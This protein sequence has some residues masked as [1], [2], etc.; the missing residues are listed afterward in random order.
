MNR[1][2]IVGEYRIPDPSPG[3]Y[4]DPSRLPAHLKRLPQSLQLRQ[5][6][7]LCPARYPLIPLP[8]REDGT[9]H[10]LKVVVQLL[11]PWVEDEDLEA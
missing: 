1:G 2:A 10:R 5:Y 11:V 3:D 6:L 8:F 9:S 4:N 7:C